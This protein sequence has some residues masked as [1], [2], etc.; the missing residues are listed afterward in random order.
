MCAQ[1]ASQIHYTLYI[2]SSF[3]GTDDQSNADFRT[4]RKHTHTYKK[5]KTNE[6]LGIK[7]LPRNELK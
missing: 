7:V 3:N 1:F 6:L 4:R 2:C 5:R